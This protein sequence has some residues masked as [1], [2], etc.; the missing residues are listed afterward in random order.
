MSA[1]WESVAS[2]SM[3]VVPHGKKGK[4]VQMPGCSGAGLLHQKEEQ[5]QAIE[6]WLLRLF[7]QD[8]MLLIQEHA[9]SERGLRASGACHGSS[10]LAEG[11]A[12]GLQGGGNVVF[13]VGGA[14]EAGLIQRRGHV[15]AAREQAVA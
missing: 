11:G 8:I 9:R 7:H 14:D 5:I 2:S 12:G 15:N 6:K 3:A 10:Q 1:N 4:R 13:A